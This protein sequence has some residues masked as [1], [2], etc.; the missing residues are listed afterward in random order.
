MY[1][2]GFSFVNKIRI[3]ARLSTLN[4]YDGLMKKIKFRNK[5]FLGNARH[6]N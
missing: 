2:L 5:I 3:D 4:I 1:N 6:K